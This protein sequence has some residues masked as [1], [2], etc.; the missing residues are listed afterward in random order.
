MRIIILFLYIIFI[1]FLCN[2]TQE[3][4]KNDFEKELFRSPPT[5]VR[6]HT[7]WHWIDGRITRKGITR[8][9]E[10]MKERGIVQATILNIGMP[11]GQNINVKKVLFDSDEWY[12]MFKWAL[13]EANRLDISIG[14]H[15]CDGWSE[16]GGP[17]ITPEMSMKKFVF[18]KTKIQANQ[19]KIILPQPLCETNFYRDV[20]VIA[21][22]KQ[23]TLNTILN[24]VPKVIVNDTIDGKA[25]VDGNPESMIEIRNGDILNFINSDK[26]LKTRISLLQNFKGTFYFPEPKTIE[27][28][29]KASNDGVHFKKITEVATNKFYGNE[30]FNIPPTTA[31]YFQVEVKKIHNLRPWHHAALAELQLLDNNE[32]PA[33]NPSILNTLE[34][35][36]SARIVDINKL[37][38]DNTDIEEDEIIDVESIIDITDKMLP[39]GTL[40]C[41]ILDQNWTVIRFGYTTTGAQNDPATEEGKGLEC[42]KMDTVAVNFHFRNF[43]KKLIEEA[44][45][46]TGNT[47][48][49]L[50]IDS[51]E[52]GYQ[53][54]TKAMPEEFEKLRGY[55]LKK[56][57][58]VL[59]GETIGSTKQ[60]DAFLYDFRKTIADLFEQN[61]YKHFHELCHRNGLEL[62]GEVIYGDTGPFPP[63]DVLRTNNYMDMP[64]YEFWADVDEQNLV[65]YI[66]KAD[67]IKNLPVFTSNF[68]NKPIIGTEAFTGFA[69]YS[70]SPA[71]LKLFGDRAFCSGINQMILHSYVHQPNEKK[72]GLSLG[73]HGSYFNRHYPS[74]NHSESWL[75]YLSRI[76]YILQKG[77]ISA[78]IL[79]YLGDQYP[80]F[81]ENKSINSLPSNFQMIPCNYD[82][83]KKLTVRNN[84]MY[85][86]DNQS[87]SILVLPDHNAIEFETLCEIQRLL[88][89]GAMVYGDKPTQMF[90]LNAT[91]K[92]TSEFEKL[93]NEIWLKYT[94]NKSG[95]NNYGKGTIIWGGSFLDI[96]ENK[97]IKPDFTSNQPDSLNLMY[98]HKN[99]KYNDVFFI[100]NQKD[101]AYY[102]ECIF[103]V[104]GNRIPTIWDPMTGEVRNLT[105]YASDSGQIQI[106]IEFKPQ[107]SLFFIFSD[108]ES[109]KHICKIETDGE[110]LFPSKDVSQISNFPMINYNSN[111]K[112]SCVS[113][114]EKKYRLTTNEGDI[115]EVNS[116]VPEI[117]QIDNISGRIIFNPLNSIK[118]DT[119][120][121]DDLKSFTSYD[122]SK[123]KYFSGDAVYEIDFKIPEYFPD[124]ES[125][126]YLSLGNF[127]ATAEVILNNHSLGSIW[128]PGNRIQIQQF[129]KTNN[130]L[131]IS[132]GTTVRNRV[133]GDLK[134][135]GELKNLWTSAP[136]E[137]FLDVDSEL[138]PSGLIGPLLLI[139]Y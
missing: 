58:P 103:K 17:W 2:C 104:S 55:E 85:F 13:K 84:K 46:F 11:S 25:L 123:I 109:P 136:V 87:F 74:W 97:N 107:Q 76:Q 127:D 83:L 86:S 121:I 115:I 73:Q 53:T 91:M 119:L 94:D 42:D 90:S 101:S 50:L 3:T 33:Y 1:F 27:Y 38:A 49:F 96:I 10:S 134:E 37:Y 68:Y 67:L 138:K 120:E 41:D 7:W 64:M 45:V 59:C 131:E 57:I 6:V 54:W 126:I 112:F 29:I 78:D 128:F 117:V 8:D 89:E 133:I 98:I 106:P 32:E 81:F 70:E 9:L 130:H 23:S 15:N 26:E 24:E 63:I 95:K 19:Q 12:E 36:A 139:K 75:E 113:A 48:K 122:D 92:K 34:K 39:D 22:K 132:L 43:P 66:P 60:S 20:A 47:F 30:L 100:V 65:K 137:R 79:Y 110:I 52:R 40:K 72:P 62:H 124:S 31:K 129:L 71:D 28:I 44:G 61:Y 18:S 16:S 88:K 102:R 125:L 135:F 105:I 114:T 14:V 4:A 108:Y 93:S 21:Y 56:W 99:T 69:H 5:E 118:T 82:V 111:G 51:W 116:K 80:Q 77:N 35:T